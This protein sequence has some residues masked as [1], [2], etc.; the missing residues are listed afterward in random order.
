MS[1]PQAPKKSSCVV[2]VNIYP[3]LLSI[4]HIIQECGIYKVSLLTNML[5]LGLILIKLKPYDGTQM[6]NK[7]INLRVNPSPD[8]NTQR[9]SH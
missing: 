9:I 6:S 1:V 3:T 2:P 7:R 5:D 4:F 8:R